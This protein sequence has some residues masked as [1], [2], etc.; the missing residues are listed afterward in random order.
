MVRQY[1]HYLFK[2]VSTD[3]AYQDDSGNW[4][5]GDTEILFLCKCREEV[6][7]SSQQIRVADGTFYLYSSL[8]QIPKNDISVTI[9]D[10]IVVSNDPE[11]NDIR[12][13]AECMRYSKDQLHSR[14]WV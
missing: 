10:I 5:G 9:G 4:V 6:N 11:C 7:G 1:P 2:V 13:K 14:L 8:I 3:E 12:I